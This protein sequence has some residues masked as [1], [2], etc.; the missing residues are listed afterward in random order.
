MFRIFAKSISERV[1]AAREFSLFFFCKA[2][3]VINLLT[4]LF[5]RYSFIEAPIDES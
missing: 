4:P 5:Q 3:N 2:I 1:F